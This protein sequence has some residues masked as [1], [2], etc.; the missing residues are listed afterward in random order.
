MVSK[1]NMIKKFDVNP[2]LIQYKIILDITMEYK[3]IVF[4]I[5][6]LL[7]NFFIFTSF[8]YISS[9]YADS[10]SITRQEIADPFHDVIKRFPN[11]TISKIN[12]TNTPEAYIANSTDIS[13][14]SFVSDGKYL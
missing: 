2:K 4:S 3:T 1:A 9:I 5:F 14:I 10:P 13:H 6:F 7:I 11:Y 12:F 8:Y